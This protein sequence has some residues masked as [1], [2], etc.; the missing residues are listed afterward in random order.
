MLTALVMTPKPD[1]EI[2][3]WISR[4]MVGFIIFSKVSGIGPFK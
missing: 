2:L 3:S 1:Y 4:A